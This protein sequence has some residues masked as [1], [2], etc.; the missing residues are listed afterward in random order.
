MRLADLPPYEWAIQVGGEAVSLAEWKE[1]VAELKAH[2][3]KAQSLA[4]LKICAASL[5]KLERQA[6]Q[7]CRVT[8]PEFKGLFARVEVGGERAAG[9]GWGPRLFLPGSLLI[10]LDSSSCAK[11]GWGRGGG[12][13]LPMSSSQA[14]KAG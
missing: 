6:A 1:L 5:K 8:L 10:F 9:G 3:K 13:L 14:A 11:E 2:D 12:G 4:G 7:P